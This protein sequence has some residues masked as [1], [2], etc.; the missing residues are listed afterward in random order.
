MDLYS[1]PVYYISFS[2]KEKVESK[3]KDLGFKHVY[4]FPAIRGKELSVP[5]L[6]KGRIISERVYDDLRLGRTEH[7][8]M[9]SLGGIG[10]TLSH[11]AIWKK[12]FDDENCKAVMIL[13]DDVILPNQIKDEDVDN[14]VKTINQ[15]NGIFISANVTRQD[16][17]LHF[18]GTHFYIVS[19]GACKK[20]MDKAFPID[21]QTDWY[22]SHIGTIKDINLHGYE[23]VP[24]YKNK[25]SSIQ[26]GCIMCFFPRDN[27]FY[28]VFFTVVGLLLIFFIYN[29][30]S[31]HKTIKTYKNR[32]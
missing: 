26:D 16:K 17:R 27:R 12:C 25:K 1:I 3:L 31:L 32:G 11:Y 4:H 15:P 28:I 5:K 6:V 14:I 7:S 10:C 8:G 18:F 2:S 30:Y 22:I 29:Y 20:L 19:K 24:Q 13:E 21:S 23:I 9:P